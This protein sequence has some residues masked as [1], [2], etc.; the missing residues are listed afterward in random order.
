MRGLHIG[1][2]TFIL[3]ITLYVVHRSFSLVREK[4]GLS[5]LYARSLY[6]TAVEDVGSISRYM[7]FIAVQTTRYKCLVR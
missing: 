1:F 4:K 2:Q 5:F 6:F 7:Y 3:V